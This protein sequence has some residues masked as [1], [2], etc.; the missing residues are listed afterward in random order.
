M[1][2]Y[3]ALF[4]LILISFGANAQRYQVRWG[5]EHADTLLICDILQEAKGKVANPANM[6]LKL[7]DTPYVAHTLEGDTEC[8]TI[9]LGGLDCTTFAETCLALAMTSAENRLGWQDFVYNLR[10]L[11]YRS[12]EVNGYSS[13]LHYICDW[14]MDNIHRGNI[15]DVTST[16]DNARHVVRSIDFMSTNR[17]RYPALSDSLQFERIKSIEGGYRNHRFP[18]LR[19]ADLSNKQV[20]KYL[21]H[22][23]VVAFV[24]NLKNLDVTHMGV[25]CEKDGQL[26]VL[27]ASS[28]HGK[29]EVST[30]PLANFVKAN[31][32][33]IGIRVFRMKKQ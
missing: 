5:D 7:L 32:S 33:W 31:R 24:S 19:T 20:L 13:R 22:G 8:L 4:I 11:R 30:E 15:I 2:Q 17:D 1:K 6:G 14:A 26:H 18:Y 3:L 16:I 23:D 25:L 9:N 28:S 29:V 12:G 27:H 21:R 10:S